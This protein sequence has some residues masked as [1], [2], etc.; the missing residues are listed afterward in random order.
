VTESQCIRCSTVIRLEAEADWEWID[1]IIT[2]N[3]DPF[4][5]VVCTSCM[6]DDERFICDFLVD[7]GYSSVYE[8]GLAKRRMQ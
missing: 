8:A 5:R 4:Q 2:S 1:S 7:N 3:Q 6:T